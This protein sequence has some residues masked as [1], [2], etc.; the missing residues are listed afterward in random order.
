MRILPVLL[1]LLLPSVAH[2]QEAPMSD[3]AFFEWAIAH[4]GER[5]LRDHLEPPR[6][7]DDVAVIGGY[8]GLLN[9]RFREMDAPDVRVRLLV[10]PSFSPE[11][12]IGIR[13]ADGAFRIVY[14]TPA[15]QLWRFPATE[16]LERG[17]VEYIGN[18]GEEELPDGEARRERTDDIVR[19]RRAALP[20]TPQKVPLFRCEQPVGA[21]LARRIEG[22]WRAMLRGVRPPENLLLGTDGVT[23]HFS[24]EADEGDLSGEIWSPPEGSTTG[25]LVAVAERMRA[26]CKAGGS[27]SDGAAL[28]QAV[29]AIEQRLADGVGEDSGAFE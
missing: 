1:L 17:T 13:H 11:W 5:P 3:E 12:A 9:D 10:V 16:M 25:L 8:Y 18:L 29:R 21:D 23:Y 22:L 19:D 7:Y 28:E 20:A 26:Y 4:G 15:T 14:L 24:M 2:A 27:E 6:S